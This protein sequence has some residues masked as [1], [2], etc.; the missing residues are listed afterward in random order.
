MFL[1]DWFLRGENGWSRHQYSVFRV[2][3]GCYLFIVSV[4][5]ILGPTDTPSYW[6]AGLSVLAALLSI[7]FIFAKFERVVTFALA[8][9][10]A[11]FFGIIPTGPHYSEPLLVFLL[12]THTE[13]ISSGDGPDIEER[14]NWRLP[15][16][17]YSL[18][19][20]IAIL[21]YTVNG[22]TILF[23]RDYPIF[24][25]LYLTAPGAVYPRTRKWVWLV[26]TAVTLYLV[27]GLGLI[28]SPL[29]LVQ[30]ILFDPSWI[31]GRP[32]SAL[33]R[34]Y[35]DGK[36]GFCHRTVLFV[37]TED[38]DGSSFRFSPLQ[39]DSISRLL[40][41]NRR[42]GLPDSVVVLTEGGE[43]FVKSDAIV[44]VGM[45]LG[46]LWRVGAALLRIIPKSVR[47]FTYDVVARHRGKLFASP[48]TACPLLPD[49][50]MQ[51]FEP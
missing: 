50:L 9:L 14:I 10:W 27:A 29:L 37:L 3:L 20:T 41:E 8:S 22:A 48:S 31:R 23:G 34:L 38:R 40:P 36:C 16:P 51:R 18:V 17:I 30:V 39:G 25:A 45:R 33:D 35:Y 13:L 12:L 49:A 2:L 19:W 44:R 15:Q 43:L 46:G 21:F 28:V 32:S 6:V 5:Q 11:L 26:L 47:D 1:L 42:A 24:A 4:L 7:L